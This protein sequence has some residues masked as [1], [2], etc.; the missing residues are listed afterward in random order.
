MFSIAYVRLDETLALAQTTSAP[1]NAFTMGGRDQLQDIHQAAHVDSA[2]MDEG[3]S[4]DVDVSNAANPTTVPKKKTS[5][6]ST[7][8]LKKQK[9]P[10]EQ[11]KYQQRR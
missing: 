5:E 9:R 6:T 3:Q 11:S 10:M 4:Q 8:N 7:V 2:I 1:A